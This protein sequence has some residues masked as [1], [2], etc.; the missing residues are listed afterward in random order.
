SPSMPYMDL[1]AVVTSRGAGQLSITFTQD[2]V[3]PSNAGYRSDVGGT[4]NEGTTAAFSATADGQ[5]ISSLGPFMAAGAFS[6]S[7]FSL[8]AD[9]S[10]PYSIS[11]Q[12]VITH[13]EGGT[14]SFDYQVQVPEPATLALLG[15]GLL[16]LGIA[17][18]RRI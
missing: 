16:A 10:S 15:L 14:S 4:L 8:F 1:N 3:L 13:T 2:G 12:A 7:G 17:R 11:L 5:S 6:G 18:R 9:G